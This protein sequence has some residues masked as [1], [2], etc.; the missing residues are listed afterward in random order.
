MT[1]EVQCLLCKPEDLRL[2]DPQGL[3]KK[4]WTQGSTLGT[5]VL[6][7]QRWGDSWNPLADSSNLFLKL[8]VSN[9]PCF[10]KTRQKGGQFLENDSQGCPPVSKH[11][12]THMHAYL[13]AC[14]RTHTILLL[15]INLSL[16]ASVKQ[17][18]MLLPWPLETHPQQAAT[19]KV[20]GRKKI[21]NNLTVCD[22]WV[23]EMDRRRCYS[24]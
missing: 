12:C 6:R 11:Q 20:Q 21:I 5:P 19:F 7:R 3:P 16:L 1:Q 15:L 14:V 13:C 4:C 2:F 24:W 9:R 22:S 18:I 8:W 23:S 10:H 17:D